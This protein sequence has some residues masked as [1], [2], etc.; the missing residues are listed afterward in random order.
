M[1]IDSMN[2]KIPETFSI[3]TLEK[4]L[5]ALAPIQPKLMQ[6]ISWPVNGSHIFFKENGKAVY[7]FHSSQYD[8]DLVKDE[9]GDIEKNVENGK[10]LFVFGIG[11]G[12]HIDFLL[13]RFPDR[14]IVVWDRDPWLVRLFLMKKDYSQQLSS[15]NMKVLICGDLI[16]VHPRMDKYLILGHKMPKKSHFKVVL[17]P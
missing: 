9:L 11:L 16:S 14:K 10:D 6:R 7:N 2:T 4:N 1:T 3:N 12:E 13:Y 8:L 17:F 5:E 15:G